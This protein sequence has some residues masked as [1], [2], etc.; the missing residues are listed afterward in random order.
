MIPSNREMFCYYKVQ[1]FQKLQTAA[2]CLG[3]SN[4][5]QIG[6]SYGIQPQKGLKVHHVQ[7]SQSSHFLE[8]SFF[9]TKKDG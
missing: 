1:P 5:I 9:E 8:M 7:P 4:K 6:I 2:V 3:L